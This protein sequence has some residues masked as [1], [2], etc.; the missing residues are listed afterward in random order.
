MNKANCVGGDRG[1]SLI[2]AESQLFVD[3]NALG[4]TLQIYFVLRLGYCIFSLR[5]SYPN[6]GKSRSLSA[7]GGWWR[8]TSNPST[9][10]LETVCCAA[11]RQSLSFR[12]SGDERLA[13]A[14]RIHHC[15]QFLPVHILLYTSTPV[16]LVSFGKK[17]SWIIPNMI[18]DFLEISF[19]L[20]HCLDA[21]KKMKTACDCQKE[22]IFRPQWQCRSKWLCYCDCRAGDRSFCVIPTFIFI[23][24]CQ[25]DAISL[26]LFWCQR[27]KILKVAV[28]TP[29][30]LFMLRSFV[31]HCYHDDA[32]IP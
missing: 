15:V 11:W 1:I 13:M 5:R 32:R 30:T 29:S 10:S 4:Q 25:F 31:R 14:S 12:S 27:W 6:F 19:R 23:L 8:K 17:L 18:H 20:G 7:W 26:K 22:N 21:E 3:E 9:C 2:C 24:P 16:M 28:C